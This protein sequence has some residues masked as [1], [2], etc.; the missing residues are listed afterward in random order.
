[1]RKIENNIILDERFELVAELGRGGASTVY[2]A[3]DLQLG[4]YWAVKAILKNQSHQ[5]YERF[6][7]E[8]SL[9]STLDH[10]DIPRIV[11][12]IERDAFLYVVMD[13][14]NGVSLDKE[15]ELKGNL[16]EDQV[17]H[18]GIKLCE[19]LE[20]LHTVSDTPIIY[21]DLKPKNI[22]MVNDQPKII[23]LGI[24][25]KCAS[26][27]PVTEYLGTLGYAA[28][29]QYKNGSHLLTPATD[30]YALGNTLY[31]CLTGQ[32][33]ENAFILTGTLKNVVKRC[34]NKNPK[35]RY[36]SARVLKEELKRI[37]EIK[38]ADKKAIKNRMFLIFTLFSMS[39][40]CGSIFLFS[41]T[42]SQSEQI[43]ESTKQFNQG[44]RFEQEKNYQEAEIAYLNAFKLNKTEEG[45]NRLYK[46]IKAMPGEDSKIKA[47]E[48]I[49]Y[50]KG[51]FSPNDLKVS[52]V[53]LYQLILD[54]AELK[55]EVIYG[56]YARELIKSLGQ[57]KSYDAIELKNLEMLTQNIVLEEQELENIRKDI[58]GLNEEVDNN[59]KL[60]QE[61]KLN[62]YHTLILLYHA[63]PT[64]TEDTDFIILSQKAK[65]II[66]E[67]KVNEDFTFTKSLTLYETVGSFLIERAKEYQAPEEQIKLLK[68]AEAWFDYIDGLNLKQ[69][70][71]FLTKKAV[72]YQGLSQGAQ[73]LGENG[74]KYR[75]KEKEMYR[76]IIKSDPQNI[77]V[78]LK[79]AQGLIED[80]EYQEGMGYYKILEK[81]QGNMTPIQQ[82]AFGS[83][84]VLMSSRG[85]EV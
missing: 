83:L 24:A 64:L 67:E 40:L 34:L 31:K 12:T 53:V 56:D 82:S 3:K 22:M 36:Q 54:I 33:F 23:D 63:Y 14:I 13:Y 44:I 25:K 9:L 76:E 21:C 55:E 59:H 70:Q 1:M 60:S 37:K 46:T 49:D 74:L 80:G 50:F 68:E 42:F 27:V 51:N 61:E 2:L 26:H 69:D 20:Y 47:M 57:T 19:I 7:E 58:K 10:P 39:L 48:D 15:I 73:R 35:D 72:L 30:I 16:K 66:E 18:L 62:H 17:I 45:L 43:K 38:G 84:R 4:R 85:M 6:L 28:P 79:L 32:I 52:P 78:L 11:Q 75:E 77:I 81:Y 65:N 41:T 29:E 5:N 8:V 71:G